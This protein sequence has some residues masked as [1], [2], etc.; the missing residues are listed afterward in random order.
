MRGFGLCSC[1]GYLVEDLRRLAGVDNPENHHWRVRF[2]LDSSIGIVDVDV[3]FTEFRGRAGQ[4]PGTVR[5]LSF[6]YLSIGA[7]WGCGT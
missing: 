1:G 4:R 6:R 3:S 5:E 2:R 7:R